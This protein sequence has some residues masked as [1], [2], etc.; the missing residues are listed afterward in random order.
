MLYGYRQLHFSCK[1][2]WFETRFDTS[3]YETDRPL[4]I[5]KKWTSDWINK[6]ELG[7]QIMKKFVG[8]K[9]NI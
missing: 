6:D 1:N 5:G 2:R 3:Y 7:G 9:K 8:L 4:F